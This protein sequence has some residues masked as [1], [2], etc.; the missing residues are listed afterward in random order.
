M[1]NSVRGVYAGRLSP[2]SPGFETTIDY[3]TIASTGDAIDFGDTTAGSGR[4]TGSSN[5]TRGVF[6]LGNAAP[7]PNIQNHIDYI[8]IA[9]TGN[10]KD[11]G[12]LVSR[13]HQAG[14]TSDSHGGLG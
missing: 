8:T 6:V 5:K 1:S 3:I 4:G 13:T 14:S 12:D 9:T 11:F 7:S 10:A 2:G